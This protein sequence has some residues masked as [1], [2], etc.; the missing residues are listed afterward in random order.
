MRVK[1]TPHSTFIMPEYQ[2]WYCCDCRQGP[3]LR[4]DS[5]CTEWDQESNGADRCSPS[6]MKVGIL[7]GS[8]K[9]VEDGNS[10]TSSYGHSKS[11]SLPLPKED[12]YRSCWCQNNRSCQLE[13]PAQMTC[14]HPGTN[15]CSVQSSKAVTTLSQGRYQEGRIFAEVVCWGILMIGP[16]IFQVN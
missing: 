2:V 8:L 14:R 13:K 16:L 6:L 12:Q 3:R 7:D 4:R 10:T 15:C 11:G 9:S 5:S 1:S